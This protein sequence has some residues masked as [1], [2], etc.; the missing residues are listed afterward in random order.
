[1]LPVPPKP[2]VPDNPF[3]IRDI[4]PGLTGVQRAK[5]AV[6]GALEGLGVSTIP[7]NAIS[8]AT[9][10]ERRRVLPTIAAQ[11]A[12]TGAKSQAIVNQAFKFDPQGRIPALAAVDP[13][14]PGAPTIED[15]AARLP[16][17]D[18]ALTAAQ[19]GAL[20][21]LR[22]ETEPFRKV[23]GDFGIG[24][25]AHQFINAPEVLFPGGELLSLLQGGS[26]RLLGLRQVFQF[27]VFAELGDVDVL[28]HPLSEG[29]L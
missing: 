25:L 1:M 17:Y 9:L 18:A 10:R 15:V 28:V 6:M 24:L 12:R 23:L 3:G 8:Q 29:P 2:P 21:Q 16:R 13:T 7:D 4:T 27:L 14:I 11:A 19:R 20:D 5:N 26:L 22:A